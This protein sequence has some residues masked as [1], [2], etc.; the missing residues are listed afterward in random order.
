MEFPP[1]VREKQG[2]SLRILIVSRA[3]RHSATTR[4]DGLNQVPQAK[5]IIVCSAPWSGTRGA[6]NE[7]PQ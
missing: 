5:C 3:P 6:D 2:N 4:L 1:F 7:G